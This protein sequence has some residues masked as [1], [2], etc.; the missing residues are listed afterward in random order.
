MAQFIAAQEVETSMFVRAQRC[1]RS[2]HGQIIG[3]DGT[4]LR[5]YARTLNYMGI[6]NTR[7]NRVVVSPAPHS[8]LSTNWS[9]DIDCNV[10]LHEI[11]HLLGLVDGYEEHDPAFGFQ[12]RHLEP[13]ESIMNVSSVL[14]PFYDFRT[15]QREAS[16]ENQPRM[17]NM[18][19]DTEIN[20]ES[21]GKSYRG[22]FEEMIR[23]RETTGLTIRYSERSVPPI[24]QRAHIRFITKPFCASENEPY[25]TC[26]TKRLPF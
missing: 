12:C 15:C 17:I 22:S 23:M 8:S 11:L 9:E 19:L 20:C 18:G 24:L 26:S 10:I 25:I 4:D 2:S 3:P 5:L 13:R 14:G 1:L 7:E 6:E 16:E 21:V